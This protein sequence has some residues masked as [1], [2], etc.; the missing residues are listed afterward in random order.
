MNSQADRFQHDSPRQIISTNSLVTL[1]AYVFW[2]LKGTPQKIEQTDAQIPR[3]AICELLFVSG[4]AFFQAIISGI[5]PLVSWKFPPPGRDNGLSGCFPS[6]PWHGE[7][8]LV[9]FTGFFGV[10]GGWFDFWSRVS[11]YMIIIYFQHMCIYVYTYTLY[12][13]NIF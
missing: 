9:E 13:H 12:I 6:D 1:L 7:V 3:T 8:F 10:L 11:L 2:F 4:V 5:Q